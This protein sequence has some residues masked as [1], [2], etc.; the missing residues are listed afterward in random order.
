MSRLPTAITPPLAQ[1]AAKLLAL[2]GP[3]RLKLSLREFAAEIK[4]PLGLVSEDEIAQILIDSILNFRDPEA[5]KRLDAFSH[6]YTLATSY[7]QSPAIEAELASIGM[8]PQVAKMEL[9]AFLYHIISENLKN[10]N[11]IESGYYAEKTYKCHAD[12]PSN[13]S[14]I[15]HAY[16]YARFLEKSCP[17]STAK[18]ADIVELYRQIQ[19]FRSPFELIDDSGLKTLTALANIKLAFAE[20]KTFADITKAL[21]RLSKGSPELRDLIKI[22]QAWIDLCDY[23]REFKAPDSPQL[24]KS[25]DH[26][27]RLAAEE[28]V[29]L[30][31]DQLDLAE[32]KKKILTEKSKESKKFNYLLIAADDEANKETPNRHMISDDRTAE[33]FRNSSENSPNF[34]LRSL[35]LS[36][37]DAL[38]D[39]YLN[40]DERVSDAWKQK[41]SG[42]ALKLYTTFTTKPREYFLQAAAWNGSSDAQYRCAIEA[43]QQRDELKERAKREENEETE[44]IL[45]NETFLCKER[46]KYFLM[47]AADNEHAEAKFAMANALT[48]GYDP[49][50]HDTAD[51]CMITEDK[52]WAFQLYRE[53][54][55]LGHEGARAAYE[56]DMDR[57]RSINFQEITAEDFEF[58]QART[59][60]DSVL[61]CY[62]SCFE[63]GHGT[64][65]DL[66]KAATIYEALAVIRSD[67]RIFLPLSS[68]IWKAIS[69]ILP[70]Y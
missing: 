59:C 54:A 19:G 9:Y 32:D 16:H 10:E 45:I 14:T 20:G 44:A 52:G 31:P 23:A 6:F 5:A 67:A 46:W 64:E 56:K 65:K 30:A 28:C 1:R 68:L 34:Y 53:A 50:N 42:T 62:A 51:Y 3:E 33:I 18:R 29:G 2:V 48:L 11:R 58:V 12:G 63:G 55:A 70:N 57:I 60:D 4:D 41:Y 36:K 15:G 27:K 8:T 25:L 66:E 49:A 69:D 24:Q 13:I 17:H 22:E 40:Y 39:F 21:T 35:R 61:M 26:I 7:T 43:A 47:L 38:Y 37:G